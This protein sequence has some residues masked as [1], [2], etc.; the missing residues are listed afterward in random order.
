MN[1]QHHSKLATRTNQEQQAATTRVSRSPGTAEQEQASEQAS[2]QEHEQ[3][4][5]NLLASRHSRS[6][7]A[8]GTR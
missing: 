8:L 6:Q 5:G 7:N 1:R 2:K 3:I 4:A